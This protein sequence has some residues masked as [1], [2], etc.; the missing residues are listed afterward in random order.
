M[1]HVWRT[2]SSG[3]VYP[4]SPAVAQPGVW[5]VDGSMVTISGTPGDGSVN[6][7]AWSGTE[8][9]VVTPE[10]D[11]TVTGAIDEVPTGTK[12]GSNKVFTLSNTPVAIDK[13]YVELRG[14]LLTPTTDF[15]LSGATLT[16]TAGVTAPASSDSFNA[17]YFTA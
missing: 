4:V 10:A 5:T 9:G 8:T 15:T 2:E 6:D 3:A 17:T 14:T 1:D 11:Y 12:N 7:P 16:L 13:V